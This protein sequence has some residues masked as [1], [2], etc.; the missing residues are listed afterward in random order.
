MGITIIGIK[1]GLFS[2]AAAGLIIGL[3]GCGSSA[4][5]GVEATSTAFPTS[6][7]S[8]QASTP[9]ASSSPDPAPSAPSGRTALITIRDFTY[10]VPASVAPGT[11]VTV[12]NQD[13]ESHTV[14]SAQGAF[15]VTAT[16]RGGTATLTAPA[17]TGSYPFVC[18]LH[19]NMTG[20]LVVK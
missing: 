7:S 11:T 20:T 2:V 14:T 3:T 6:S 8:P 18:T 5:P 13:G 15:N 10:A 17:K 1:P 4:A 19:G 16:A 12:K 9:G